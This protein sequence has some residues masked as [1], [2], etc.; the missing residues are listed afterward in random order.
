MILHWGLPFDVFTT[1]VA[2]DPVRICAMIRVF[3][4]LRLVALYSSV[5]WI[6][7][8]YGL[9]CRPLCQLLS[10]VGV[11]AAAFLVVASL[12]GEPSPGWGD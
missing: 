5:I 11:V 10:V 2:F 7:F 6:C 12:M 9:V 1:L 4:L 3:R 8:V